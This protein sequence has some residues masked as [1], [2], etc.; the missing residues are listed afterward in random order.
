MMPTYGNTLLEHAIWGFLADK[1]P[2]SPRIHAFGF[3]RGPWQKRKDRDTK[4]IHIEIAPKANPSGK[5][6][7]DP[8]RP[9]S[10]FADARLRIR[11]SRDLI[12]RGARGGAADS[13]E[14]NQERA[15]K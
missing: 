7:C 13:N 10:S 8:L 12:G 15:C 3:L 11:R 14:R 2:L 6:P 5:S 4:V 9:H 1:V